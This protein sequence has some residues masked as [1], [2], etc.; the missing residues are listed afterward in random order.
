MKIMKNRIMKRLTAALLAVAAVVTGALCKTEHAY[1]YNYA[2]TSAGRAGTVVIEASAG[3]ASVNGYG[4]PESYRVTYTLSCDNWNA[5]DERTG[6]YFLAGDQMNAAG[7]CHFAYHTSGGEIWNDGAIIL[8]CLSDGRQICRCDA[9][10]STISCTFT[11]ASPDEIPDYIAYA[12]DP[13]GSV[14]LHINEERDINSHIWFYQSLKDTS[15]I[16]AGNIDREAPSL[17]ITA[18]PD[19]RTVTA[20]GKEWALAAKLQLKASDSQ[21]RPAGIRIY[22]NGSLLRE[23]RNPSNL[24]VLQ[25]EY[26]IDG[27][28]TYEVDCYDGLN[29]VSAKKSATVSFIDRVAPEISVEMTP[30]G[31]VVEYQGQ[32]WSTGA[33]LRAEASDAQSGISKLCVQDALGNILYGLQS[34][35]DRT[36]QALILEEYE[37]KNGSYIIG[38][39]DALG[40]AAESEK[41]VAA[42]I[43]GGAPIIRSVS[44]ES[45][46]EG[47]ILLTVEAV[48]EGIGLGDEAYS[49]DGGKTWQ[50]ES[51]FE[52]EESGNYDIVVRDRLEQTATKQEKVEIP[53]ESG[54]E[55]TD[56]DKDQDTSENQDQEKQ[57]EV[58]ESG[59]AK[60]IS[61]VINN[62]EAEKKGQYQT[63]V[64]KA[65]TGKASDVSGNSTGQNKEETRIIRQEQDYADAEEKE[66]SVISFDETD[67]NKTNVIPKALLLILAIVFLAGCLGLLLYLLLFYLRYSCVLYETEA[68]EKKC[69]LCRIPVRQNGEDW[70]VEVPDRKLGV[71]GN[72]SYILKFHPSFIKEET[73]SWVVINI[74]G[75]TLREKLEEEIRFQI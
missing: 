60:N 6:G 13:A 59:N 32:L 28:G 64:R 22:Q 46:G 24:A 34:P 36:E 8:G 56:Q 27:N 37:I 53:K 16:Y 66:V 69:R 12:Y 75:K 74:D 15:V 57:Q 18:V 38:A 14:Y 33:V 73:P 5:F 71:N 31:K 45:M 2:M 72:N 35:A 58:T 9:T 3:S 62:P 63:S 49:I 26:Q 50:K 43:D 68:D 67:K 10:S 40:N 61:D 1:A 19:G 25:T 55:N 44:Q 30:K 11:V 29:Y 47:K 51:V 20:N 7:G 54:D 70:F 21:S 17:T 4:R 65:N 41:V 23:I 42:Y 48:D 39:S 52:I